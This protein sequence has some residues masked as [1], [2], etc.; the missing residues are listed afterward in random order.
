MDIYIVTSRYPPEIRRGEDYDP[1][2]DT[3]TAAFSSYEKAVEYIEVQRYAAVN[4]HPMEFKHFLT[5]IEGVEQW[6]GTYRLYDGRPGYKIITKY[7][8]DTPFP[9]S[10]DCLNP[11]ASKAGWIVTFCNCPVC[12]ARCEAKEKVNG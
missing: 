4:P 12:S 1:L 2:N 7:P 11:R 3:F 5:D 8:L 10:M 6:C 9:F